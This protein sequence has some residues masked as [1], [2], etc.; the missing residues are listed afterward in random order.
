MATGQNRKFLGLPQTRLGQWG[1]GLSALF[2]LTFVLK[3]TLRFPFPSIPIIGL[4]VVAGIL[5]LVAII[6]KRERS[7]LAWLMFLP[8]LFAILLSAGEL[9]FPH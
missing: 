3:L 9:L 6:W 5:I 7:W 4:G 1:V 8:G 2:V